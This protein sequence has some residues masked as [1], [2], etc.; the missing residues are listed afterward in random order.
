MLNEI[1]LN[2]DSLS[3]KIYKGRVNS[4]NS[5][6]KKGFF[7]SIAKFFNLKKRNYNLN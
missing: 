1:F 5:K 7:S 2:R 4:N 6:K 3:N